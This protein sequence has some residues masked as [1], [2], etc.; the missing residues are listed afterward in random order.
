[1][2]DKYRNFY[3]NKTYNC[4][5]KTLICQISFTIILVSALIWGV[6]S[7]KKFAISFISCINSIGNF[8][9]K[10]Q[11]LSDKIDFDIEKSE[12]LQSKV[13]DDCC[14]NQILITHKMI[15]PVKN[16]FLSCP[17]GFR[18]H[19]ITG[20]TDFHRGIDIAVP[21]ESDIY[22][23][24][25][26]QVQEIGEDKINGNYIII[27]HGNG[28]KTE[29]CHCEKILAPLSAKIRRGERIAQSGNTGLSTGPHLHF[30][31]IYKDK[32]YDPLWLE[33]YAL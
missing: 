19:P 7:E 6:K 11:N 32:Y 9:Y 28:L 2:F 1:M 13:P 15:K 18:N 23:V 24:L 5:Y 17:F 30:A 16:G 10:I 33:E 20:N 29:Y 3:K 27:N 12:F 31:V 25:D 14:L 21:L 8:T 4:Y 22:A 26:G